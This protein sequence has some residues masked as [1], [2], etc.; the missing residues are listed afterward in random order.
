MKVLRHGKV[1]E[2]AEPDEALVTAAIEA[3]RQNGER[4][5]QGFYYFPRHVVRDMSRPYAEQVIWERFSPDEYQNAHDAMTAEIER[6]RFRAVVEAVL[7]EQ[8][9]YART[10]RR[11][12]CSGP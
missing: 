6:L 8:D 11:A 10:S 12:A 5:Y 2:K 9:A 4:R 3:Y 1:V 7:A